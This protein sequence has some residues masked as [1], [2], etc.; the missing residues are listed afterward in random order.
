M[1]LGCFIG[2]FRVP[3]CRMLS[4]YPWDMGQGQGVDRPYTNEDTLLVNHDK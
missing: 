1:H 3:S 4:Q 2:Y